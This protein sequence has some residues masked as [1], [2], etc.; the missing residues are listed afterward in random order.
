MSEA[1][2]NV[3]EV[4]KTH[5]KTKTVMVSFNVCWKCNHR[6]L[7]SII[8]FCPLC[9]VFVFWVVQAVRF[10]FPRGKF[11]GSALVFPRVYLPLGKMIST[12]A[13]NSTCQHVR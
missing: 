8:Y 11:S 4:Y 6:K 5:F 10:V 2:V 12:S 13:V 3:R 1:M 7:D 9:T